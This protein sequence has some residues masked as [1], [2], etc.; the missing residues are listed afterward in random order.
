ME[1]HRRATDI[2]MNVADA[3]MEKPICFSIGKQRFYLY[4]PTLGKIYLLNR[5]TN[6]LAINSDMLAVN[7][8]LESLRLCRE[9]KNT[10]SRILALHSLNK[11]VD[12]QD[13]QKVSKIQ[14]IFASR[15]N[16]DELAQLFVIAT[17]WDDTS[18]YTKHFGLDKETDLRK[19]IAKLKEDGN[20]ISF[21][22][23]STYGTMIDF[24]CQRYGWTFD[25]VVWGISYINLQML[26]ADAMTSV[27]LSDEERK[28]LHIPKNNSFINADDPENAKKI[29]AMD[30]N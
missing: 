27:Y 11:K 8:F 12:I 20:N 22:G 7:P 15:L 21:G 17:S 26:M 4:P 3:I 28:K 14:K 18:K 25:Y 13:E 1:E 29:M 2:E 5:L 23:R 6:T 24:A 16:I 30:W 19:R 10:I 9:H